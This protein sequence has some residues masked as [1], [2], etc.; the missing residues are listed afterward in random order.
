MKKIRIVVDSTFNLEPEFVKDNEITIVPLNVI[1]D[2]SS[3][4]DKVNIDL[5]GVMS[6]LDEGKKV[7]T[8]QPSP[9]LFHEAFLNLRDEGATDIICLTISSTLSGTFQAANIGSH[10]I[11]GVNIHIIDSLTTSIGGEVLTQIMI[12]DLNEGKDV[13]EVVE[14]IKQ[15]RHQGAILM[16]FNDL[17]HLVKSGR[18][19]RL[20]ATI[21]NLLRVKPIIECLDG[22]VDVIEKKRTEKSVFEFIINRIKNDFSKVKSKA[23]IYVGHVKESETIARITQMLQE[24]FTNIKVVFGREIS[25]VV[26]INLGYSGFGV[27]FYYE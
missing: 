27:A 4:Q 17:K 25:P 8:S 24:T 23:Y 15:V 12:N 13:L 16:N 2:N 9:N 14:K 7:T 6:A 18:M 10:D 11:E 19:S 1:I 22:N 5:Q 20:K 3:Y 26:A 21:G